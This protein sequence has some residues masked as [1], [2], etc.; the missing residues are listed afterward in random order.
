MAIFDPNRKVDAWRALVRNA[1]AAAAAPARVSPLGVRRSSRAPVMPDV[2][3]D[4]RREEYAY[5]FDE[6]M[7]LLMESGMVEYCSS[8]PLNPGCCAQHSALMELGALEV[9]DY[10]QDHYFVPGL[11]RTPAPVVEPIY[12]SRCES[13]GHQA[14]SCPFPA[15]DREVGRIAALRRERRGRKVA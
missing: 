14:A 13:V 12:C 10:M 11:V 8:K 1:A 9:W 15:G 2:I 6:R 4:E 7:G 5:L 3:T